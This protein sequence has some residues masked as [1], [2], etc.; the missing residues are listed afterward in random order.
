MTLDGVI[1]AVSSGDANSAFGA[2][3]FEDAEG[4]GVFDTLLDDAAKGPAAW[5]LG[6][7]GPTALV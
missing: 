7:G 4:E 2:P 5:S 1:A 3:S 6:D